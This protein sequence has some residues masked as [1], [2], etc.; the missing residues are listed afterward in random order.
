M[1]LLLVSAFTGIGAAAAQDKPADDRPATGSGPP[2]A[3][4]G[5]RQPKATEVGNPPSAV[6]DPEAARRQR[7]LDKKLQICRGC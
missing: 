4:V 5:H 1:A 6:L 3:P 7:A 2:L